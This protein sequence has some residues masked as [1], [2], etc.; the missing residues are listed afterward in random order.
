MKV[1]VENG[2]IKV[3]SPYNSEFIARARQ[4]QGKWSSPNWVFPE[5]NKDEVKELLVECYGECG[6]LGEVDTV[7]IELDLDT[8]EDDAPNHVLMFGSMVLLE[9][10]SRDRQPT[11]ADNVMVVTGGFRESGGSRQHPCVSPKEG[12]I[13]RVKGVPVTVYNRF[14]DCEGVRL[15]SDLD[16]EKLKAEREKLLKRLAEID[17]LLAV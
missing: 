3:N 8:Y 7:T 15:V 16:T 11:F 5:E 10:R 4:I 14:K 13:L 1:T 9:R 12:T 17:S 6:D 2:K